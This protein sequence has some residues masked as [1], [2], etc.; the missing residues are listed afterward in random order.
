MILADGS[1][2]HV[3]TKAATLLLLSVM[4]FGQR[5]PTNPQ[6][7]NV[8]L[9]EGE[10]GQM[11]PGWDMTRSVLDAGYRAELRRQDCGGRFATCVTFVPPPPAGDTRG[12]EIEQTFPAEPY[13]GKSI[14]FSAWLRMEAAGRGGYV[15]IRMRA[16]YA[17]GKVDMLD[18]V[19]PPVNGPE[20]QEREV[21]G[22]VN[23]EA[24]SITIWARRVPSG[25]AW[26][27]AP[28]F[29]IV[30]DAKPS[31]ASISARVAWTRQSASD[32]ENVGVVREWQALLST[33]DGK[34]ASEYLERITSSEV[35]RLARMQAETEKD[36]SLL[37]VKNRATLRWLPWRKAERKRLERR[38]SEAP[39]AYRDAREQDAKSFELER[40]RVLQ[41]LRLR[42]LASIEAYSEQIGLHLA[43]DSDLT[44][45]RDSAGHTDLTSRFVQFYDDT[46]SETVMF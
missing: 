44:P 6:P 37:A 20:W 10:I 16:D 23:P 12:T 7:T 15:H 9:S 13:I 40:Q 42:L 22:H 17:S 25:F 29:G 43:L 33:R 30:A 32:S 26:V 19:A 4:A 1:E 34:C 5:Q 41:M 24:V 31:A 45:A 11:P 18:S 35:A 2:E 27:A 14:R 8:G 38:I 28:S 46:H 21:F 36:R 39:A 3:M